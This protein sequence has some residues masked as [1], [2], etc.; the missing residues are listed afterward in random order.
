MP[1][2]STN[3]YQLTIIYIRQFI[4]LYMPIPNRSILQRTS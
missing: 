1:I 2:F 4:R 3:I